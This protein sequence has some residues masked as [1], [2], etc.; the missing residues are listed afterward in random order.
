MKKENG[1]M[2]TKGRFT[3]VSALSVLILALFGWMGSAEGAQ[4]AEPLVMMKNISDQALA[5]LRSGAPVRQVVD[6]QLLPHVALSEVSRYVVGRNNWQNASSAEQREFERLFIGYLTR[7][8]ESA[9]MA[10]KDQK[11]QFYPVGN[12]AGKARVVVRT[13]V[14]GNGKNTAVDYN[15][16]HMGGNWKVYD[17]TVEGISMRNSYRSQFADIL[18]N[19]GFAGLISELKRRQ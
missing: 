9:L 17:I 14:S 10:C 15:L 5:S 18:A 13:A 1:I 16:M 19:Q 3:V 12:V 2:Q 8:Y 6:K 7:T 11:I 4:D